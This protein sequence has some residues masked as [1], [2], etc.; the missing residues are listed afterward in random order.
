MSIVVERYPHT[1][2]V[3]ICAVSVVSRDAISV[4]RCPELQ[5]SKE[6]RAGR[7]R[8]LHRAAQRG[9]EGQAEWLVPV[10]SDGGFPEP[11][12]LRRRPR[13][14]PAAPPPR[15]WWYPAAAAAAR[16]SSSEVRPHAGWHRRHPCTL[17][18]PIPASMVTAR[19]ARHDVRRGEFSFGS[20]L[21]F[22]RVPKAGPLAST[23]LTVAASD[24]ETERQRWSGS[25]VARHGTPAVRRVAQPTSRAAECVR[26]TYSVRRK[27]TRSDFS[28]R[29][30]PMLKRVS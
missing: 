1:L 16:E 26:V 24:V 27:A 7:A 5:E 17:S 18:S 3:D 22:A 30:R 2:R 4:T 9:A 28:C 14:S 15:R 11:I 29:V 25:R 8:S 20:F 10:W 19:R 21:F 13:S 12:N 6:R 23:A